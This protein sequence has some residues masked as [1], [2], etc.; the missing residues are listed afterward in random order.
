MR[1]RPPATWPGW[2]AFFTVLL[3]ASIVVLKVGEGA[4]GFTSSLGVLWLFAVIFFV[5]WVLARRR[6]GARGQDSG[7]T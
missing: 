3:L 7:G 1:A 5:Q 2:I 4:N 6:A